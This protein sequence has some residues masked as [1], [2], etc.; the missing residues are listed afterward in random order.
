[1]LEQLVPKVLVQVRPLA[2]V[3]LVQ[4]LLVQ[5]QALQLPCLFFAPVSV[6]T[7]VC[8]G[9]GLGAGAGCSCF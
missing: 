1:M 2:L 7:G 4:V 3:L 5:V 6:V 9:V 8:V